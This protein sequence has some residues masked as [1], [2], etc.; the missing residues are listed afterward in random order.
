[1]DCN[2]VCGGKAVKD[3]CNV[4]GGTGVDWVHHECD[5]DG[6][7]LD[8]CGVCGGTGVPAGWVD[9]WTPSDSPTGHHVVSVDDIQA[10]V[11]ANEG[12]WGGKLSATLIWNNC[13]DLDLWVVEPNGNVVNS[14]NPTSATGALTI[15]ANNVNCHTSEAVEYVYYADTVLDGK[16]HAVVYYNHPRIT[17]VSTPYT[18]YL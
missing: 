13:N 17:T 16:Y 15:N 3:D 14:A 9:C 12:V 4:C 2:N 18:L 10:R 1:M 7:K 11:E 5:C 8:V 6:N